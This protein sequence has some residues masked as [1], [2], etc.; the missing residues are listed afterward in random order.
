M[1]LRL[2]TNASSETVL[3]LRLATWPRRPP[4]VILV[5]MFV[6][7]LVVLAAVLGSALAPIDPGAQDLLVG[8]ASPSHAHLL[9]T[10]DLGRDV[11]SRTIV[12]ARTAIIGPLIIAVGSMLIGNILGLIAGYMGGLTDT[13]ISRFADLLYALPGLLLAIVIVGIVGGGYFVGVALLALLFSPV[14]TRIVRGATLEQRTMAYVEAAQLLGLSRTRILT[15]HIWW[16]VLPFAVANAFLTFA[17]AL[18]ALSGL[19]FLGLG[20]GPGAADW[21]QMLA[22]SRSLLFQNPW[23]ALAPGIALLL[24]AASVNVIGDWLFERLS[25]RG[26]AR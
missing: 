5:A 23:T 9:G 16:N 14:D 22:D 15:R 7:G 20:V 17:Y 26:R 1:N 24:T 8:I 4:A 21:G 12:G 2:S 13:I 3:R 10:D 11:L 19:A 25:D 6:V 18:V